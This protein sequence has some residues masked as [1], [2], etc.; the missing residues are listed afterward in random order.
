MRKNGLIYL[1][2]L[3]VSFLHSLSSVCSCETIFC[4][5]IHLVPNDATM[6]GKQKTIHVEDANTAVKIITKA[7]DDARVRLQVMER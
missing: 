6:F 3:K 1:F 4:T 2:V 7:R 5:Y